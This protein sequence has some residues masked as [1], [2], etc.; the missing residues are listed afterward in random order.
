MHRK[1]QP[2][3]AA[4]MEGPTTFEPSVATP[5]LLPSTSRHGYDALAPD[6]T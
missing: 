1:K 5:L 3:N 4:Y 2:N 6:Y